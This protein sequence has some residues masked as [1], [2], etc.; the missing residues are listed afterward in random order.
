MTFK[1]IR[2][3]KMDQRFEKSFLNHFQEAGIGAFRYCDDDGFP[4]FEI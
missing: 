4:I 3:N 2:I 1:N